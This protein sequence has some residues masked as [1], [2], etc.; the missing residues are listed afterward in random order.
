MFSNISTFSGVDLLYY[1]L[2]ELFY[3]FTSL[4]K[5]QIPL[6]VLILSWAPHFY[7]TEKKQTNQKEENK[8]ITSASGQD[9]KTGTSFTLQTQITKKQTKYI[10]KKFSV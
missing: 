7:S 2:R 10:K 8:Q 9:E 6:S 3:A 1:S 5:T 4:V